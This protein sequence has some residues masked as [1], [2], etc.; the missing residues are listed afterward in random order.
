MTERR[1]DLEERF[2]FVERDV[3]E[4]SRIVARQALML[5][6]LEVE[7]RELRR[8]AKATEP[9]PGQARTLEDDRPPHY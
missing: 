5:E 4:L 9:D 6:L 8:A 7:V 3:E 2:L 1:I